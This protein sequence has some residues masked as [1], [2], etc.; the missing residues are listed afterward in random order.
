MRTHKY[1]FPILFV[2]LSGNLANAVFVMPTYAPV[3]RLITNTSAFIKEN[4]ENAHGYYTL[5][6]IHYLA[7]V[8]KT[9]L[10]G[11]FERKT[12]P[13]IAPDW[14]L[15]NFAYHARQQHAMKLTLQELG[16]SSTSDIPQEER[17]AF[18]NA[19]RKKQKQLEEEGW[20]YEK[21]NYQQLV[22]HAASAVRN[23]RKAI[24]LDPKNGLYQ[25]GFAGLLEQYVRFLREIKMDKMPEEFRSIILNKAKDIYYTAY[26]LS[27]KADLK[28]KR[29]P[30]AGLRS[31]VGYEAG[32]A[33]VRLSEADTS[34]PEDEQ[35]KL[36]KVKKDLQKLKGLRHGAIT[37]IIFSLE[38]HCSL[39]DLLA[40][41]L[42]V[43]FDLDGDG[44]VEIC[45]WVKPTT[46][47]LV[48]DPDGKGAITSGRQLFGSVSWWLFFA[49]GYHALDALDDNRDGKL[50]GPELKGISVW[51]DR[52]CDGK[53][54][55]G[56]VLPIERL[57]IVS[58]ATKS[59]DK[60]GICPMNKSGLTL[61]DGRTFRTYD[62]IASPVK[63]PPQSHKGQPSMVY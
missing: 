32:K 54:D 58:I 24:E 16:Y 21:L 6:R 13:E 29:L 52:D 40:P 26:N 55:P 28:H 9:G 53:S 20:E 12:P 14:L 43:P 61:M 45:P 49:D 33:Y 37:P 2:F 56:E 18:W 22:N 46:G 57:P 41:D 31:L 7:F 19:L 59:T 38:K 1:L 4:P 48:W 27:I 36:A 34:T 50:S 5:G 39:S 3:E 10:V 11:A 23:F 60:D 8:N 17:P 47:I 30:I 35:K 51:F 25:L 15:G 44:D 62:W 42:R 63:S